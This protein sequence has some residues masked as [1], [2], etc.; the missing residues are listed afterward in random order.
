MTLCAR[1]FGIDWVTVMSDPWTEASAFGIDVEYPVNDLPLI[2]ADISPMQ[3][4]Q[5]PL[6]QYKPLKASVQKQT[7]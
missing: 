7:D 1:D 4:Q 2:R 6:K 3:G 5:H